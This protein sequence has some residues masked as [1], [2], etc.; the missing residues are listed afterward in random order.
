MLRLVNNDLGTIGV[1][2]RVLEPIL[3]EFEAMPVGILFRLVRGPATSDLI[4]KNATKHAVGYTL[5]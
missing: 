1:T 3:W 5:M 2:V 4:T